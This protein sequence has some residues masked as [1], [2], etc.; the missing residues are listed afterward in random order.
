M[1]LWNISMW[2]LYWE[3]ISQLGSLSECDPFDF[4]IQKAGQ[5]LRGSWMASHSG[6]VAICQKFKQLQI[7]L[8]CQQLQ[9]W[10]PPLFMGGNSHGQPC[11]DSHMNNPSVGY[12]SG[13][14]QSAL[15]IPD[16]LPLCNHFLYELSVFRNPLIQGAILQ[17]SLQKKSGTDPTGGWLVETVSSS[18]L[19]KPHYL[20]YKRF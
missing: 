7:P 13:F 20:F 14:L 4:R 19:S 17:R 1:G 11:T 8:F 16:P 3:I 2:W 6:P 12:H 15:W 10:N 9:P 18:N 5:T